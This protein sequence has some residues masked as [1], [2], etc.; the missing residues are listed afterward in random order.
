LPQ[1]L[2]PRALTLT[3]DVGL[4]ELVAQLPAGTRV[5]IEMPSAARDVDTPQDLQDA[6]RRFRPGA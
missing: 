1:W 3:G 6:R 4:R 5:L 2:Y